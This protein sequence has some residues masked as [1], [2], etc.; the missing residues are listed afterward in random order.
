MKPIRP[1]ER[2]DEVV[3]NGKRVQRE[4]DPESQKILDEIRAKKRASSEKKQSTK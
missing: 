2:F 1:A 3:I 4:L